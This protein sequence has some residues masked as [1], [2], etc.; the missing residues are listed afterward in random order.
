MSNT[1]TLVVYPDLPPSS[2]VLHSPLV[3]LAGLKLAFSPLARSMAGAL[4]AGERQVRM[5]MPWSSV[6]PNQGF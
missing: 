6:L 5:S 2:E 4:A 3:S 1:L